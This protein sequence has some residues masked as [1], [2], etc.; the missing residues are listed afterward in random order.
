AQPFSIGA[1]AP[2]ASTPRSTTSWMPALA[3]AIWMLGFCAI[4]VARV[5]HWRHVR[6][7]LRAS[8]PMAL[9]PALDRA[10][11]PARLTPDR[12]EPGVVG[13]IRPL[14][15]MPAGIE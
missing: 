5:R 15:L 6:A 1:V 12:L 7:A 9:S 10:G 11:V 8:V 4:G 13:I 14:L 3:A 2:A